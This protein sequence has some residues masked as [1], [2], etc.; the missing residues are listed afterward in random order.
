MPDELLYTTDIHTSSCVEF[1]FSS[2][3]YRSHIADS[4]YMLASKS[5]IFRDNKIT[6][7]VGENIFVTCYEQFTGT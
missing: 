3:L 6:V 2:F 4:G 7:N 5:F 1:A